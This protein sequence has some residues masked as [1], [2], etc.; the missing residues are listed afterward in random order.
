MQRQRATGTNG[1]GRA[2]GAAAAPRARR[3][4]RA[5][6]RLALSATHAHTMLATRE[7]ALSA[8]GGVACAVWCALWRGLVRLAILRSGLPPHLRSLVRSLGPLLTR[9]LPR[10][11]A[12]VSGT[13][14]SRHARGRRLSPPP[15]PRHNDGEPRVTRARAPSTRVAMPTDVVVA[16]ALTST[17]Q[18][19]LLR[20]TAPLRARRRW[21]LARRRA[22]RAGPG[23]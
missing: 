10:R 4:D 21:S 9:L 14:S 20:R 5:A 2:E 16:A 11:L 22:R 13:R 7:G 8:R 18:L 23:R 1:E 17:G 12:R 6:S 3:T 19:L 15:D